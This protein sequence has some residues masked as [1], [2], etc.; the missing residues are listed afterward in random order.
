MHVSN[1]NIIQEGFLRYDKAS[2]ISFK[3]HHKHQQSVY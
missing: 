2:K 3:K 1:G